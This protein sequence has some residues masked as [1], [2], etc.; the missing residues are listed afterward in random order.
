MTENLRIDAHL[1]ADYF[2]RTLRED[3]L[4]YALSLSRWKENL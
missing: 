4:D 3:V 1:D 2:E